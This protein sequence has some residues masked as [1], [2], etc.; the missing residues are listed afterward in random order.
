MAGFDAFDREIRIATAG[1]EAEE[2]SKELA[3]YARAE[4]AKAI[5]AGASPQYGQYVNGRQGAPEES[6]VPPGPIVYEF[7]NWP[8]I[9]NAALAELQKRA[10]RK[11]G[12]FASSFIVIVNGRAVATD[13]TKIEP[14]AEIIITNFQPTVRKAEVGYLGIPEN[15]LF[16]GAKNAMSRRFG[17]QFSFERRFLDIRA[18]LH[19]MIPYRLKTAR[20][21]DRIS[22]KSG[23]LSYP[24]IVINA[25]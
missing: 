4:L 6:V 15:R 20:S 18:G 5:S 7:T 10:P 23:V 24:A 14:G 19:P 11:S 22:R 25:L 3:R 12:R 13:F 16:D 2:I 21:A 9:I 1:L 17:N 8:L